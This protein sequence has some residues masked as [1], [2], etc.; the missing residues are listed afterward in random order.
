M[1]RFSISLPKNLVDEFDDVWLRM[2]YDNRSKAVHDALRRFISEVRWMGEEKI[3]VMGVILAL[4]YIDKPRLI[5]E[6]SQILHKYKN[7]IQSIQQIFVEEN[8]IMD[9]IS[10]RGHVDEI[11]E[12]I[13]ELMA[14]K[15][16]KEVKSSIIS[17]S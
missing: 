8:K 17:L 7:Y 9:I 1:K 5:E 16:V 6:M 12:L 15:G 14:K 13:Q 10:I 4:Y 3:F 2:K 11:K